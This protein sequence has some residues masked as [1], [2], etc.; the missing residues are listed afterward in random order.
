[1]F[2]LD[3]TRRAR[4]NVVSIVA[5][6][7][8]WKMRAENFT[9]N[10]IRLALSLAHEASWKVCNTYSHPIVAL[11]IVRLDEKFGLIVDFTMIVTLC[12]ERRG[13]GWKKSEILRLR[14]TAEVLRLRMT[15]KDSY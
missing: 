1:M 8:C 2:D 11:H 13:W 14:M 15:Y 10:H 12:I 5:W 7:K 9:V 3:E 6:K 4:Q